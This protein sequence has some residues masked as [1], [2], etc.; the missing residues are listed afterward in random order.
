ML[1]F[2]GFHLPEGWREQL[3]PKSSG[4]E[5]SQQRK[6]YQEMSDVS[7]DPLEFLVMVMTDKDAAY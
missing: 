5:P 4:C 6:A 1:S 3:A 7:P 2:S